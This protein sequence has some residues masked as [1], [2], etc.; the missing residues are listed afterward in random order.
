MPR[1]AFYSRRP[2]TPRAHDH[3]DPSAAT[4]GMRGRC[5]CGDVT[6]TTPTPSPLAI[7]VCH[8]T[9]CRHQSSS[10]F[11]I[12]ALFPFFDIPGAEAGNAG[13][14]S[15]APSSG[16]G[17]YTRHT[18][19]GRYVECL[20]CCNCGSR[21]LHRVRDQIPGHKDY[22][23]REG[24]VPTVSVKAGCLDALTKE[25]LDEATHIWCESTVVPI[26]AGVRQWPRRPEGGT[27]VR[28]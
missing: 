6:F 9:E 25:A 26:P 27:L 28:R 23:H 10:A 13:C 7:Y 4:T 5:Q 16:I 19:L 21:L 18:A 8:C 11:G 24:F 17:V 2:Y 20:F 15:S 1:R 14:P 3:G 12:T 22:I